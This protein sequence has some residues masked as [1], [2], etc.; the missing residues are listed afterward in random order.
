M[1]VPGGFCQWEAEGE[2]LSLNKLPNVR[3][4]LLTSDILCERVVTLH[5][6]ITVL[7]ENLD[8]PFVS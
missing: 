1:A 6:D 2:L 7:L 3:L 8:R 4:T 5:K